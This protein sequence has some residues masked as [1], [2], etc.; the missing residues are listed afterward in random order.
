MGD[1][2]GRWGVPQECQVQIERLE[3]RRADDVGARP[4]ADECPPADVESERFHG[5]HNRVDEP[6]VGDRLARVYREL[7]HAVDRRGGRDT[8]SQTQS[9]A[10][11]K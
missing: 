10:V 3:G 6:R 9:G 2:S 5:L 1:A 8:T 7:L 4:C 11:G